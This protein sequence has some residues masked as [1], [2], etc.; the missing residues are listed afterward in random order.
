VPNV[1]HSNGAKSGTTSRFLLQNSTDLNY[2]NIRH[3][4]NL[5]CFLNRH[6]CPLLVIINEAQ[7]WVQ[8]VNIL[9]FGTVK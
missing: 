3:D 2:Q 6:R 5:S 7:S 9:L 4:Q 1:C 8:W